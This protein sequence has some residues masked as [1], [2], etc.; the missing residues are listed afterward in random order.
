MGTPEPL[1][2]ADKPTPPRESSSADWL[3]GPEEG[4]AAEMSRHAAESGEYQRPTLLRPAAPGDA[5]PQRVQ[6][7]TPLSQPA[8][9]PIGRV[10]A[11]DVKASDIVQGMGMSW[12]PG[13]RS[14][15]S[16]RR[17]AP[18][19]APSPSREFPMDD[20]EDRARARADAMAAE[21]EEA[22][23]AA[24]PHEV[25]TPDQFAVEVG[26]MPWWMQGPW[27]LRNDRRIQA[28]VGVV[29]LALLTLALWPRGERP[30]SLGY[31]RHHPEKF[32]G[33]GVLVRGRVGQVF[34]VGGGYA[35]NL[36]DARDTL[37]VFTRS[38]T[39]VERQRVTLRGT[40]STGYLDGL[41]T[42]ALFENPEPPKK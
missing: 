39:P 24:R 17:D 18:A 2:P 12:E 20:A 28:L 40:L 8:R 9:P 15:P 29:L 23:A 19:P 25:V 21:A 6:Q 42:L 22:A 13:T 37:V 4:L 27:V 34:R 14:V 10:G 1:E 38:R 41:P 33:V 3:V 36:L 11:D 35:F 7:P 16:V 32:D 31:L 26:P 30:M 5:P